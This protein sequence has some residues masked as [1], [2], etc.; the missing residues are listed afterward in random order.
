MQE[1]REEIAR[2][3]Y[4]THQ[5]IENLRMDVRDLRA[6]TNERLHEFERRL[7]EFETT[8][9]PYRITLRTLRFITSGWRLVILTISA[10]TG[11]AA[12]I[13]ELIVRYDLF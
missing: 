9:E 7:Y 6:T 1:L 5:S 11:L 12:L 8:F 10:F 3:F 2:N 4:I 13:A